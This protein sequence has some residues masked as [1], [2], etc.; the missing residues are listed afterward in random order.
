MIQASTTC[1]VYGFTC[2]VQSRLPS[3]KST[4]HVVCNKF[5]AWQYNS[6]CFKSDH[7]KMRISSRTAFH[8]KVGY[9]YIC[10][11]ALYLKGVTGN[12]LT[13]YEDFKYWKCALGEQIC[14]VKTS[15][16]SQMNPKNVFNNTVISVQLPYIADHSL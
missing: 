8:R 12:V 13:N 9:I 4:Q 3:E 11:Q 6:G 1:T 7:K 5:I 16:R 10:C 15:D 14:T 2:T